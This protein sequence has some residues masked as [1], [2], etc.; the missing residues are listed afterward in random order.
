M[1]NFWNILFI[2]PIQTVLFYF[3][4]LFNSLG[5]A[6]VI[7]TLVIQLILIPLRLPSL[8]SAKKMQALKPH[9]DALKDKH[10]EDK[11]ALMKA[12]SDLYKEHGISPFGGILPTLLSFPIIIALYQVLNQSLGAEGVNGGFLWLNLKKPDPYFIL[13]LLV[14]LFQWY[15]SKMMLPKENSQSASPKS[16]SN[17][18]EGETS[19]EDSMVTMQRQMQFI[20]PVFSAFIVLS[21]PSGVGLYWLISLIF[22]VVQQK[23]INDRI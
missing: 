11:M 23:I 16:S 21:L 15:L 13:P 1:I 4:H 7:L 12:Q 22:S 10:K 17:K 20:F 9:L 5:I 2:V 3:A 6:I 19:L 8:K 14:A 18:K